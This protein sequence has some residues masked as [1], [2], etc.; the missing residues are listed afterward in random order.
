MKY[1]VMYR[2]G[3]CMVEGA[4]QRDALAEF[5]RRV[6]DGEIPLGDIGHLVAIRRLGETRTYYMRTVPVLWRLGVLSTEEA[7]A[8]LRHAVSPTFT[9][10]EL[11]KIAQ[12]DV[13]I[14]KKIMESQGR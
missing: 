10:E 1:L 11:E 14:V 6:R 7:L 2:A 8:S 4:S 13:W 9:A 5:F 3:R 12:D